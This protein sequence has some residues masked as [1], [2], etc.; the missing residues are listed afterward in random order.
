M[1][2][3][4]LIYIPFKILVPKEEQFQIYSIKESDYIIRFYPPGRDPNL[5]FEPEPKTITMDKKDAFY[6]NYIQIDFCKDDFNRID[7][8][9]F[10]PPLEKINEVLNSFLMRL[11]RVTSSPQI[12]SLQINSYRA[13]ITYLNN[14]GKELEEEIGKITHKFQDRCE[15][16]F[17]ALNKELW[18]DTFSIQSDFTSQHWMNLLL[19]AYDE[20]PDIGSAVVLAFTALEIFIS[21]ILNQLASKNVSPDLWL[22]INSRQKE[23]KTVE[24][25]DTLLKIFT[26]HSLKDESKLWDAFHHLKSA[27]DTFVHEGVSRITK[28]SKKLEINEAL[29]LIQQADEITLKIREWLPKEIQ[30][31]LPK[32]YHPTIAAT[33]E[34]KISV[35]K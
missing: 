31:E 24:Q 10:D 32:E 8:D 35:K 12:H 20:L 22:W 19:D 25:Y 9:I 13:G 34:Y 3:R 17:V 30:W 15:F 2:A 27:R 26:G 14:N 4:V 21:D 11:K 18:N 23:P 28:K 7:K 1:I 33:V 16:K 5:I 29:K 6:A